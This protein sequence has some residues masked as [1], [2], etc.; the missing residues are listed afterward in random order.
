M[1]C[2]F[3]ARQAQLRSIAMGRLRKPVV[4][5]HVAES[6]T[7]YIPQASSHPHIDE[8]SPEELFEL[9]G[10]AEDNLINADYLGTEL[11]VNDCSLTSFTPASQAPTQRYDVSRVTD[12]IRRN[13]NINGPGDGNSAGLD[14]I[15]RSCRKNDEEDD[16]EDEEEDKE[17][18]QDDDLEQHVD[19]DAWYASR[20]YFI[21]NGLRYDG[22]LFELRGPEERSIS[23]RPNRVLEHVPGL[24][25]H[26]Q[27]FNR[28]YSEA[29]Y[30]MR[31]ASLRG[32]PL[33][34]LSDRASISSATFGE[35]NCGAAACDGTNEIGVG[36]IAD[37]SPP[38]PPTPPFKQSQRPPRGPRTPHERKPAGCLPVPPLW[39]HGAGARPRRMLHIDENASSLANN[40]FQSEQTVRGQEHALDLKPEMQTRKDNVKHEE[41]ESRSLLWRRKRPLL[42]R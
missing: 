3:D 21:H 5:A 36:V 28:V 35:D 14:Y 38:R 31:P 4:T 9:S 7:S 11:N 39:R 25:L 6:N 23:S 19:E 17:E 32:R 16:E 29:T 8:L 26:R 12:P 18:E 24:L 27:A 37:T 15:P 1:H 40:M 41:K 33:S 20:N 34:V 2:H 42:R 30:S 22:D 13:G 10:I